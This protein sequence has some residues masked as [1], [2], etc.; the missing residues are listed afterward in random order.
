MP[1]HDIFFYGSFF[2]LVGIALGSLGVGILLSFWIALFISAL[3]FVVKEISKER[4]KITMALLAF[5]MF[6][7]VLYYRI[8]DHILRNKAV[9]FERQT[10]FSGNVISDPKIR[11]NSQEVIVESGD[12]DNARFLLKTSRYPRFSYGENLKIS[13]IIE[14]PEP[15]GYAD[16]LAKEGISGVTRFPDVTL[17]SKREGFSLKAFLIDIKH[18]LSDSFSNLL[19]KKEALFLTGLTLGGTSGFSSEFKDSMRKSGTTHLVALSGYN[20]TIIAWVMFGM[21][22]YI[23]SRRLSFFCTVLSLLLFV[24]I[25]GAETSVVRAAIMGILVLVARETGKIYSLRNAIMF[26]ALSMTLINPKILVFDVG[27]Q[28]SFLALLGIVYLRPALMTLFHIRETDT[29]FLSLKDNF[30]TTL[31]AQLAVLPVL[32]SSFGEISLSS[33]ISNMLIL[34][35][36]PII[37]GI[38]ALTALLSFVSYYGALILAWIDLVLLR[39]NVLVIEFFAAHGVFLRITIPLVVTFLYYFAFIVFIYT[40]VWKKKVF[41]GRRTI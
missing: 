11:E 6:L 32:L 37:M 15:G 1:S 19:P 35:V 26:T 2:F 39:F 14:K 24:G 21:F 10:V 33:V 5:F 34:P 3:F 30:F 8:D 23:F 7:G 40:V 25:A 28:L 4:K 12:M 16:Y 29:R 27:F 22:S 18:T 31:S 17:V 38:G 41:H 20:I 13:G 36:I 9:P